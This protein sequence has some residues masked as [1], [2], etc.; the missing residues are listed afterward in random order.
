MLGFS[1]LMKSKE[2]E[3]DLIIK[4]ISDLIECSEK[5]K[6]AKTFLEGIAISLEDNEVFNDNYGY[7]IKT[8]SR[9]A[10]N[11]FLRSITRLD[12]RRAKAAKLLINLF[13]V[14]GK[15]KAKHL[16]GYLT[17]LELEINKEG[18]SFFEKR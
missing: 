4:A 10:T 12:G 9:I 18:K 15:D 2:F 5:R 6:S 3:Q 14:S 7:N 11:F 16:I 17:D 8:I 1:M 13:E